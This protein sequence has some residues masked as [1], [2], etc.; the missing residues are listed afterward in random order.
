[1]LTI[2]FLGVIK[3]LQPRDITLLWKPFILE[4]PLYN[5]MYLP[6]LALFCQLKTKWTESKN[7]FPQ[8][9]QLSVTVDFLLWNDNRDFDSHCKHS[10]FKIANKGQKKVKKITH[11]LIDHGG[12]AW[13]E[14]GTDLDLLF[15]YLRMRAFVC[16]LSSDFVS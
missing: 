10:K 15:P 4:L 5:S 16:C 13:I 3:I 12:E 11:D 9:K 7:T 8:N 14:M 2:Y 1:M 6:K